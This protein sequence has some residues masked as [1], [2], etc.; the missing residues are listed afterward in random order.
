MVLASRDPKSVAVAVTPILDSFA[1]PK[2]PFS[3]GNLAPATIKPT[4][5]ES[6]QCN[7]SLPELEDE[8]L[9]IRQDAT[10]P[11]KERLRKLH[12]VWKLQLAVM[13]KYSA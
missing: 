9:R 11:K 3:N 1:V 12:E 5:K 10:L 6:K 8:E 4:A 13:G 2:T 7:R